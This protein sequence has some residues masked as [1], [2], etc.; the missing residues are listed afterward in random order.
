MPD[1]AQ[2]GWAIISR[3][4]SIVFCQHAADHVFVDI[5]VKGTRDLSGDAG[6]ANMGIA[7]FEFDDRVDELLRWPF[8]AGAPTATRREK[9]SIFPSLECLMESQQG[10]GLQDDG[11]LRKPVPPENYVRADIDAFHEQLHDA[12]LIGREQFVP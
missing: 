1:K 12:R 11:E 3:S 5:D 9:P 2:P 4:G 6:T 7:A 8:W 10:S